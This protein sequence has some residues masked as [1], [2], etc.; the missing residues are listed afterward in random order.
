VVLI[1]DTNIT[2]RPRAGFAPIRLQADAQGNGEPRR[3]T[4]LAFE[5]LRRGFHD[6]FQGDRHTWTW[7]NPAG[8]DRRVH[9][10]PRSRIDNCL[11][12]AGFQVVW[13]GVFFPRGTDHGGLV[14]RLRLRRGE[15]PPSPADSTR[16][17]ARDVDTQPPRVEVLE[18]RRGALVDR[19]WVRVRGRVLDLSGVESLRIDGRAVA[20][21]RD[22]S[23]DHRVALEPGLN[24]IAIEARDAPGNRSWSVRSVLSGQRLEADAL[25]PG[26]ATVRL[27]REAFRWAEA[28][29]EARLARFDLQATLLAA[30][31]LDSRRVGRGLASVH[32]RTDARGASMGTPSVSLV[33][34]AGALEVRVEI[35]SVAVDLG[36]VADPR[37]GPT[38]RASGR[39]R[40]RRAVV[41]AQAVTTVQGEKVVTSLRGTR[42]KLHGFH[43]D[44][45]YLPS[46]VDRWIA[47]AVRGQVASLLARQVEARVPPRI[48]DALRVAQTAR[49]LRVAGRD[50]SYRFV[51][52]QLSWDAKGANLVLA[53]R[54]SA[55]AGVSL[56]TPGSAPRLGHRGAVGVALDDDLLNRLAHA[57][58]R[59]GVLEQRLTVAQAAAMGA[60]QWV[61]R[62]NVGVFAPLFPEALAELDPAT[63]LLLEVRP[64]AAPIVRPLAGGAL[65]LGVGDLQVTL[66]ATPQG[67]APRR[68][69]QLYVSARLAAR[70]DVDAEGRLTVESTDDPEIMVDVTQAGQALR[71]QGLEA[72][73][74][75]LLAPAVGRLLDA[76][77]GVV[78][79]LPQRLPAGA[80]E[81]RREG[82]DHLGVW[83]G[84]RPE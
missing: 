66:S 81:V 3:E 9:I 37:L 7:P 29:A 11:H 27:N 59:T 15:G 63:P 42:V 47:S 72:L 58:W 53:A 28:E 19:D 76:W 55:G 78:V 22:G 83:W 84:V 62:L 74:A 45:R 43:I 24:T 77:E 33:P 18:P 38:I 40:A 23:F 57:A 5:L 48:D 50:V 79:P 44:V 64:L 35:P 65:E 75:D 61:E 69:L 17:P 31:P 71:G 25:L 56:G 6:A 49:T 41:E 73:C 39:I 14:V 12:G 32:V 34:A 1:G 21:G 16:T 20:V 8:S 2:E 80:L 46:F 30:N 10:L 60:P 54:L 52:Q 36:V 68:F 70:A 82:Q 26:A 67:A 4:A 13:R 51:T